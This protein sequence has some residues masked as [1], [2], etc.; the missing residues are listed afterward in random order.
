MTEGN[1]NMRVF[2]W[3]DGFTSYSA[4]VHGAVLTE[5][6]G[7]TVERVSRLVRRPVWDDHVNATDNAMADG[8]ASGDVDGVAVAWID[9]KAFELAPSGDFDCCATGAHDDALVALTASASV[10][11]ATHDAE[12]H[13]FTGTVLHVDW[14]RRSAVVTCPGHFSHEV[15]LFATLLH[16]WSPDRSEC[17][18]IT[19]DRAWDV[20]RSAGAL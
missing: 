5:R 15:P 19:W 6:R 16:V 7:D 2:D 10:P 11:G 20:A 1:G 3:D 9:G 14:D 17:P 4:T 13:T 8:F 12:R 18:G